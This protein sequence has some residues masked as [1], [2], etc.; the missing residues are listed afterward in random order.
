MENNTEEGVWDDLADSWATV[1]GRQN[2]EWFLKPSGQNSKEFREK[3]MALERSFS[4]IY[5]GSV[6]DF[7]HGDFVVRLYARK[8]DKSPGL[9]L[10][11]NTRDV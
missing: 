3:T 4:E 2:L 11:H 1:V 5:P 7:G 10:L 8:K 9:F 6:K